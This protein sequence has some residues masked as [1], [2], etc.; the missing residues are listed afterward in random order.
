[1]LDNAKTEGI[2]SDYKD[3]HNQA[4]EDD[5]KSAI[6]LPYFEGDFWPNVIEESIKEI[7]I[8]QQKIKEEEQKN[9]K[10]IEASTDGSS[11]HANTDEESTGN[12]IYKIIISQFIGISLNL[13]IKF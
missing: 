9:L 11:N 5:F 1:M 12:L 10:M 2:V 6:E 7:E 8:E 3:I 13:I 4:I